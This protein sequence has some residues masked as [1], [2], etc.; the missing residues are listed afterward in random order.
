MRR[1]NKVK[2][3]NSLILAFYT[4]VFLIVGGLLIAY[5]LTFITPDDI[6][7][8]VKYLPT[9]GNYRLIIGLIGVSIIVISLSILQIVLGSF[10]QEKT[11]AYENPDGQITVSLSAIEDLIRRLASEF[12]EVK[13][14]K[15]NVRTTRKGV[16]VYCKTILSQDRPI[17]DVTQKIQ[18]SIK[19]K[20]QNMLGIEENLT[21][22]IYVVKI[23]P[24]ERSKKMQEE[25][26]QAPFQ[27]KSNV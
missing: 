4:I 9:E 17:P 27:Y 23:M 11:I 19:N 6:N 10:Q 14:L 5:S 15:P 22:K 21:V 1:I 7:L 8:V 3:F 2:I 26:P 12:D 16:E 13:E 18:N 20:I 24:K 25:K